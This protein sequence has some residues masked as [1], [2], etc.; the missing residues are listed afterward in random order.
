M[1]RFSGVA[2]ADNRYAYILLI[3]VVGILAY[4]NTLHVPFVLDDK[5]SIVENHVIKSLPGFSSDSAGLSY[6]PRRFFGYLSFA[7]NY[8]FGGLDVTGYHLFNLAVHLVTSILVYFFCFLT[9]KTPFLRNSRLYERAPLICLVA[10]LL[11]VSHPVQTQA[12][13]YI[14]QRVASMATMFYVLAMTLYARAR[15]LQDSLRKTLSWKVLS[16]FLC[17]IVSVILAMMTKEI[18]FTLP[19]MLALY[20][21][22]FFSGSIRKKLVILL[23]IMLTIVIIPLM[24]L[25]THEPLGNLLSDMDLKLNAASE[26]SR[27]TYLLTQLCVITTYIRLLFLPINQNLDYAYPIYHSLFTSRVFCSFLF[28]AGLMATA[29]ILFIRSRRGSDPALRLVA[30]GI[31]WFF[32][33][34]SVESSVIPITDV[35]FEH[36]LYLPS[37]GAFTAIAIAL[38]LITRRYRT[39]VL[40][41]GVLVV[42]ALLSV[43]T[44][45]RNQV[46][47]N[48]VTLWQDTVSKSP[49][50]DRPHNNLGEGLRRQGRLAEAVKA[51]KTALT[52]N[53]DSSEAQSNL[54][55]AYLDRG[56]REKAL[57]HLQTAVRLNPNLFAAH[58]N[59]GLIYYKNGQ[60]DN[61][62]EQFNH[63]LRINPD[64]ADAQNYLAVT[65]AAREMLDPAIEH[66]KAAVRLKPDKAEYKKNLDMA[67]QL[68]KSGK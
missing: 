12:V 56:E 57:E 58:Y 30:F 35:I 37:L 39:K 24:L 22:F 8:R 4:S 41:A 61:A 65:Y 14:S 64:F 42:V 46:W 63:A 50:K 34:L 1:K 52:I 67:R 60:L 2:I 48:E 13:T 19:V 18:A 17:S 45:K 62:S 10:A 16:L 43:A 29:T 59:L 26:L 11:F 9:L 15:L 21:S 51:V 5:S 27:G 25:G 49:G 32:I 38:A 47:G 68:K 54:G 66:F 7:L 33:T 40:A 3:L 23:P 36:R 44:W 28:L 31:F 55:A 6:N 20:E 53:P